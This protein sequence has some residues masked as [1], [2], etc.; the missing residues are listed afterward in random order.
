MPAAIDD[1]HWL[2][3]VTDLCV[4]VPLTYDAPLVVYDLLGGSASGATRDYQWL[5]SIVEHAYVTKRGRLIMCATTLLLSIAP[6]YLANALI[7]AERVDR[8]HLA[9]HVRLIGTKRQEINTLS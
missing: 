1:V 2:E 9:G 3:T 6:S 5:A 8:S 4:R 7:D